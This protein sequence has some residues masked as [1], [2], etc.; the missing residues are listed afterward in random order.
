MKSKDQKEDERCEGACTYTRSVVEL[1]TPPQCIVE[2]M[3]LPH[4]RD[5]DS[6]APGCKFK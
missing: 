2:L 4:T 3:T 5:A 6:P 1:L